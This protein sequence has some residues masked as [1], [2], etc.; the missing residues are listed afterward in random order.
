MPWARMLADGTPAFTGDAFASGGKLH[1][2]DCLKIAVP[3]LLLVGLR[4]VDG[5]YDLERLARVHGALL[6]IER[7]VGGEHD[8]VEVVEGKPGVGCRHAAEHRGV[9]IE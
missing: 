8:L 3:N 4:H 9:G 5:L 1:T 6:R 7:A 2:R